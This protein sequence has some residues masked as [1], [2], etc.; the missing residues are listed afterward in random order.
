MKI[1]KIGFIGVVIAIVAVIVVC[2]TFQDSF[3]MSARAAELKEET[4]EITK[5]LAD[6]TPAPGLSSAYPSAKTYPK[7]MKE[8]YELGFAAT[9]FLLEQIESAETQGLPE[10]VL[11]SA[12]TNNLHLPN[13]VGAVTSESPTLSTAADAYTP[14]WYARQL[15]EFASTVPSA[16]KKICRSDD[17]IEQKTQQLAPFGLLALPYIAEE[18]ENGKKEWESYL[19]AHIIS[20][21]AATNF[22]KLFVES[23]TFPQQSVR[24]KMVDRSLD[25][26]KWIDRYQTDLDI[27]RD[28]IEA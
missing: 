4:A 11:M 26:S 13:M 12:I 25:V 18:Y 6:L 1:K 27:L 16:V 28:M 14:K 8:L 24:E 9:P 15:R 19:R 7:E 23:A 17:T 10:A 5:T 20:D 2:I 22:Q 21:D 3:T